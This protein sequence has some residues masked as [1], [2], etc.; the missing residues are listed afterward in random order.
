[1]WHPR[2]ICDSAST[3]HILP[4]Q[5]ERHGGSLGKTTLA[6]R[7]ENYFS[8]FDKEKKDASLNKRDV[9]FRVQTGRER[10]A[11]GETAQEAQRQTLSDSNISRGNCL[12]LVAKENLELWQMNPTTVLL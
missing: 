2:G 9:K 12:H 4:K 5:G 6:S 1:M 3:G 10:K 8:H 7:G 11:K